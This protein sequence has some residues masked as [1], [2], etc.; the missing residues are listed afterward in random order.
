VFAYP[1]PDAGC[2]AGQGY[3]SDG[4]ADELE[5]ADAYVMKESV[6]CLVD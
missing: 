1:Y 6:F 5:G 4:K 2:D 3:G